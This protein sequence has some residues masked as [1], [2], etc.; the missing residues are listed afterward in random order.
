MDSAHLST[1]L[2]CLTSSEDLEHALGPPGRD[3]LAELLDLLVTYVG[4]GLQSMESFADEEF[5]GSFATIFASL[6]DFCR[7]AKLLVYV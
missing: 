4:A 1:W 2:H 6:I 3:L 7:K 5:L